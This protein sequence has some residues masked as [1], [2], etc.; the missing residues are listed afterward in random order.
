[1]AA[2]PA[3]LPGAPAP[4]EGHALVIDDDDLFRTFVRT[5][6]EGAGWL[7]HEANAGEEAI[8]LMLGVRFDLVVSDYQLGTMT[9]ID[10]LTALRRHDVVQP[11]ILMSG[12]L[13]DERRRDAIRL[14]AFVLEK[15]T[16]LE[17]LEAL[18]AAMI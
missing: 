8:E 9:G 14:D 10:V 7:V 4:P 3:E 16:L 6:F 5:V 18:L 13:S 11:F 12:L 15:A 1:V 17:N 2:P